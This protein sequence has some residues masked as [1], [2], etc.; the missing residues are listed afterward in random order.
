VVVELGRRSL[1]GRADARV[2]E[3]A[4]ARLRYE[5]IDGTLH[6]FALERDPREFRRR[7]LFIDVGEIDRVE[8][9]AGESTTA[10]ARSGRSYR[11]DVHAD[12]AEVIYRS[13][14]EPVGYESE[15]L[16]ERSR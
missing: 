12:S 5:V 4:T 14:D 16:K 6:E 9:T 1:A 8:L 2:A 11:I 13:D 7:D 3:P 15:L 10:I